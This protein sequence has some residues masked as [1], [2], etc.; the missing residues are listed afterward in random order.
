MAIS[1]PSGIPGLLDWHSAK[2]ESQSKAEGAAIAQLKDLSGNGRDTNFNAGTTT[3][4][5]T[6][7]YSN[8]AYLKADNFA[9]GWQVPQAVHLATSGVNGNTLFMTLRSRGANRGPFGNFST[10]QYYPFSDGNTYSDYCSNARY[11]PFASPTPTNWHLLMIRCKTGHWQWNIDG[12]DIVNNAANTYVNNPTNPNGNGMWIGNINNVGNPAGVDM[13]GLWIYDHEV[14]AGEETDF[15]A[16]VANNLDG[17]LPES[18]PKSMATLWRDVKGAGSTTKTL[19][20]IM[21]EFWSGLSGLAPV[22]RY[23]IQDH[24]K[25][26]LAAHGSGSVSDRFRA[27]LDA[28]GLSV[29]AG[30]SNTDKEY[31]WLGGM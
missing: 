26:A 16:W 19:N 7:G 21:F 5:K 20:Q 28:Q 8:G 24:M 18:T 15:R 29:P 2:Y 3:V 17:G 6:G 14:T 31:D 4:H 11:G 23:S 27:Y 12:V 30:K 1:V 9:S 25:A 10:D 13:G 22:A